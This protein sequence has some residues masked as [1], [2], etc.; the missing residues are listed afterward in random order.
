[1]YEYVSVS[2]CEWMSSATPPRGKCPK[3]DNELNRPFNSDS[4][5]SG[6]QKLV[7]ECEKN[8]WWRLSSFSSLELM[9]LFLSPNVEKILS[10]L[11]SF[12]LLRFLGRRRRHELVMLRIDSSERQVRFNSD[13]PNSYMC[14]CTWHMHSPHESNFLR[15][16]A[17]KPHA[18]TCTFLSD[19]GLFHLL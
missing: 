1:M 2:V 8:R 15:K 5:F 10:C 3:A 9:C 6:G 4:T 7:D 14:V 13:H 19:D 18:H 16:R 17:I 11:L 12:S